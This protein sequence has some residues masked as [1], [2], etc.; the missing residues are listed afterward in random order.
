M[1]HAQDGRCPLFGVERVYGLI[2][3]ARGELGDSGEH[4]LELCV[5]PAGPRGPARRGGPRA[6]LR[7]APLASLLLPMPLLAHGSRA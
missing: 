5:G 3:V 6:C 4:L 7:L 2:G 1:H